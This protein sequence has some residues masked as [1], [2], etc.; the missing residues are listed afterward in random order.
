MNFEE[1]R[2]SSKTVYDGKILKLQVDEVSLPDGSTSVRECVRHHG[3]AAVLYVRDGEILLV[4]QYRYLYGKEIWEIPA[5][6]VESGE[7]PLVSALRELE[8]ETGYTGELVHLV[9]IYPTPG[10]TDEVIYVYR[11]DNCR[12]VGE[13]H[14]KGE[15]LTVKFF[16]VPDILEKI[17]SGEIADAKTVVAVYKYLYEIKGDCR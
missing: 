9:N 5:G 15:F 12:Y 4:R 13:K 11:A 14:D 17:R 7:E 16:S 6:K 10:Y 3:G 1:K 8:E 2:L